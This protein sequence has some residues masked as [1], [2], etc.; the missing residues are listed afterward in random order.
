MRKKT[1]FEDESKFKE[2]LLTLGVICVVSATWTTALSCDI[3]GDIGLDS[4]IQSASSVV[5][6]F[7]S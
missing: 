5:G 3:S 6:R 7:Q 4:I 2:M 1:F